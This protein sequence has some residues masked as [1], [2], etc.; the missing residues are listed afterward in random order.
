V[1]RYAKA[2]AEVRKAPNSPTDYNLLITHVRA[3]DDVP[4]DEDEA[5]ERLCA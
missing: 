5:A 1:C 2:T 3:P 4:K